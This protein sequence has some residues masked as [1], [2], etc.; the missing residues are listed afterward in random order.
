[1]TVVSS[2]STDSRVLSSQSQTQAED[3]QGESEGQYNIS[4]LCSGPS[5]A[6]W[7]CSSDRLTLYFKHVQ[8]PVFMSQTQ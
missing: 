6:L 8:A 1:M 4:L 3:R 7:T 5:E 2:V